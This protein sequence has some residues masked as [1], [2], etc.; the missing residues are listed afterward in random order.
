SKRRHRYRKLDLVVRA[1][2]QQRGVVAITV[3]AKTL[4]GIFQIEAADRRNDTLALPLKLH[5]GEDL[6]H[7]R[8]AGVLSFH[9]GFAGHV[10]GECLAG[11]RNE[12]FDVLTNLADATSRVS[13]VTLGIADLP[14]NRM[15]VVDV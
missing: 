2:T 15:F 11:C 8:T 1:R 13:D 6:L 4:T 9:E 5:E 14:A 7:E 10:H 12:P 3:L